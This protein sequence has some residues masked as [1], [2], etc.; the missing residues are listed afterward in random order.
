MAYKN[1]RYNRHHMRPKSRGGTKDPKNMLYMK[2][3]RHDAWHLLFG[4]RTISEV[5]RL[6][7]RIKRA[8]GRCK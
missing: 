2:I 7:I 3:D 8:K 5:I 1:R 4:N 6:L